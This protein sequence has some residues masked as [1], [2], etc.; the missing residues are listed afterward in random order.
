MDLKTSEKGTTHQRLIK[1]Q[2]PKC[3]KS[4]EIV[5]KTETELVRY[6]TV[7]LL[8]ITDNPKTAE[9]PENVCD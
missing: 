4:L 9:C 2:C 7:C 5:K 3:R 1:N 6:C 8:S